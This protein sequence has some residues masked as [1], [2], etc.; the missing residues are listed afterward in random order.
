MSTEQRTVTTAAEWA[1]AARKEAA[2]L[3]TTLLTLPSG[4]TVEVCRPDLS[5]WLGSGALP[6]YFV[7]KIL[8]IE[9]YMSQAEAL[10]ADTRM[11]A[12]FTDDATK[13]LNFFRFKTSAVAAAVVRPRIKIGAKGDDEIEPGAIPETD[14]NFIYGH[15][16]AGSPG[17]PLTLEEK[18][19]TTSLEAVETFPA[20]SKLPADGDDVREAQSAGK[21]KNGATRRKRKVRG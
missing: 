21:P 3:L 9:P 18:G 12:E 4:R 15:V 16:L 11:R 5:V 10:D 1:E 6:D 13:L 14:F 17:V 8:G 2:P 7:K 19:A 20:E